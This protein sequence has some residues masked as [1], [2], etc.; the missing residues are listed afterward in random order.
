MK[1]ISQNADRYSVKSGNW[2]ISASSE[3][4]P[5]YL[6]IGVPLSN[7]KPLIKT[8]GIVVKVNDFYL[9]S[10]TTLNEIKSSNNPHY[11]IV[12]NGVLMV[13]DKKIV[14]GKTIKIIELD[15][16]RLEDIGD[17]QDIKSVK[18]GVAETEYIYEGETIDGVSKNL[19]E[20]IDYTLSEDSLRGIDKFTLYKLKLAPDEAYSIDALTIV[21]QEEGELLDTAKLKVFTE[22][23]QSR[24]ALLREDFN[25]IK[26][27][28]FRGTIP[29]N[30]GK[31]EL[32]KSIP[33][34][35][36]QLLDGK[37]F[38]NVIYKEVGAV[39]KF[40]GARAQGAQGIANPFIRIDGKSEAPQARSLRS[41]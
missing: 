24:L 33:D 31:V 25:M 17:I 22:G 6:P 10:L 9:C 36:T 7:L 37:N 16:S 32:G 8:N 38:H 34:P 29:N 41:T 1:S 39:Q 14:I 18:A 35:M 28:F 11:D 27:L 26:F 30:E 23:V 5:I 3:I 15:I 40:I 12:Q 4:N 21:K 13:K 2:V 20:Q 19:I